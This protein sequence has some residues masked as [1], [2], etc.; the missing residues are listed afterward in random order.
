MRLEQV[1]EVVKTELKK[2]SKIID[3]KTKNLTFSDVEK[4]INFDSQS[5]SYVNFKRGDNLK[6]LLEQG[7]IAIYLTSQE[8]TLTSRDIAIKKFKGRTVQNYYNKL[9]AEI[10]TVQRN[11]IPF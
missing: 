2:V 4:E 7:N 11:P 8:M 10:E 5:I 3:S 9:L 6:F 1:V